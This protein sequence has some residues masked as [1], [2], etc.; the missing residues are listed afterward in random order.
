MLTYYVN[1]SYLNKADALISVEDRGFN[2]SDGVYEVIAFNEKKLLN[3]NKHISR[4]KKSL[5]GISI[6]SPFFNFKSLELIILHL[7]DLNHLNKGFIYLQITRGSAKRN[8]LFP[9]KVK[10]NVIIFAFSNK[11]IDNLLKGVKVGT[12]EDARWLRCDLKSIS[13][14]PNLLEK[15]KAYERGLYEIWQKRDSIITEGSTSNA[16]IVDSSNKI[17]THPKNNLILGGVTR[18]C[19][20]S[21][22][23]KNKILFEEKAF[24]MNDI[25]KC[26]EAFLT[27][28]TVGVLPVIKI[29]NLIINNKKTGE[30]TKK[31]INLYN[32]FLNNQINE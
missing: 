13:L 29:D 24:T 22:A 6:K 9:K 14:L 12:S 27:S 7:I 2:F 15:Q 28:T 17:L 30:I 32:Q 20:I 11:N 10:P 8:H 19:V 16:F 25:K 5:G 21:L 4:L 23:K 26:K 31:I 18:D 3:F 1:G